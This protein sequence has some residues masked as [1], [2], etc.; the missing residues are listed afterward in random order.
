MHLQDAR[1][2]LP[3][4]QL[5]R[6]AHFIALARFSGA[7]EIAK[8]GDLE[9]TEAATQRSVGDLAYGDITPLEAEKISAILWIF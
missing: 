1:R 8:G 3:T 5:V 6:G 2:G 7:D 4:N 9:G